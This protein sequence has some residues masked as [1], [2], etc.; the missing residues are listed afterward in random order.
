MTAAD[1][2]RD[3][4]GC[5]AVDAARGQNIRLGGAGWCWQADVAGNMLARA[6]GDRNQRKPIWT[7]LAARL[8][9]VRWTAL[10]R[11]GR[12]TSGANKRLLCGST[13]T[14]TTSLDLRVDDTQAVDTVASTKNGSAFP[15]RRYAG[16]QAPLGTIRRSLIEGPSID[17]KLAAGQRNRRATSRQ[18]H[19]RVA[20]SAV[21][22]VFTGVTAMWRC[23]GRG[24]ASA[25]GRH[26]IV[27]LEIGLR[28]SVT[29]L[30][31]AGCCPNHM[32]TSPRLNG[33]E[34]NELVRP[35]ETWV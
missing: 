33:F 23:W 20:E 22:T 30:W 18:P 19:E 1:E 35:A 34:A 11:A 17:F 8:T 3:G 29:S 27:G 6:A 28:Q 25:Q 10:V 21:W 26:C 32:A 31:V 7:R 12:E 13:A 24:L 14:G 4:G 9:F 2:D 15:L 16:A 5:I